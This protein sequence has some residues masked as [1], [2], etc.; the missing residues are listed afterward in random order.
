MLLIEEYYIVHLSMNIHRHIRL[1]HLLQNILDEAKSSQKVNQFKVWSTLTK[2]LNL[3]PIST[4]LQEILHKQVNSETWALTLKT[5]SWPRKV[6][7]FKVLSMSPYL[8]IW[9]SL[10]KNCRK[11]CIN[12]V[13]HSWCWQ[14]TTV[15]LDVTPCHKGG[16][17]I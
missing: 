17:I 2:C 13:G 5:E 11:Y 6:N 3:K 1:I 14:E 12:K 10:A 4:K 16:G 9:K 8:R 7:Q 15:N